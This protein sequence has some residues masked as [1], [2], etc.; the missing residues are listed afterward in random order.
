MD[1]S[2]LKWFALVAV[3]GLV[4]YIASFRVDI[5]ASTYHA[6]EPQSVAF[7]PAGIGR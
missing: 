7:I 6:A 1:S 2:D 5:P 4:A 3:L